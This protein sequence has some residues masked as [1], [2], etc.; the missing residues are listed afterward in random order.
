MLPMRLPEESLTSVP[1]SLLPRTACWLLR[2]V[3]L[4]SA[5]LTEL[6]LL[7]L[8]PLEDEPDS[9][10]CE[11][12]KLESPVEPEPDNP[13][14]DDPDDEPEEPVDEP[15]EL[16]ANADVASAREAMEAIPILKNVFFI[17]VFAL[18]FS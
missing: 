18:V 8:N 11:P 1:I 10:P 14:L 6:L 4:S 7:L 12:D 16:C 15:D 5:P 13:E 9:M 17:L 2:P 3:A